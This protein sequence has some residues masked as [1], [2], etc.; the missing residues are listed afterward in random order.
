MRWLS[1]YGANRLYGIFVGAQVDRKLLRYFIKTRLCIV[2]R[3]V[4]PV[5][6]LHVCIISGHEE[7]WERGAGDGQEVRLGFAAENVCT[8]VTV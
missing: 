2:L 1:F 4:N 5:C 8:L 6:V 7:L 3:W